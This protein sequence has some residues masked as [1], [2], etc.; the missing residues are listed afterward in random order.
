MLVFDHL[1][2]LSVTWLSWLRPMLEV[3]W[4]RFLDCLSAP[5]LDELRMCLHLR[6]G[7]QWEEPAFTAFQLRSPNVTNLDIEGN[8]FSVPSNALISALRHAP[9]LTHLSLRDCSVDDACLRA[10]SYT[11]GAELLVPHLH[12]LTLADNHVIFSQNALA[13]TIASRWWADVELASP[14]RVPAVARWRQ[15]RL[16]VD[17]NGEGFNPNSEFR[18]KMEDLHKS[19]L[20]IH[21]VEYDSRD[22]AW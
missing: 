5:A 1:R 21:F 18:D 13:S 4:M 6:G 17:S 9:S 19:G 2:I 8:G 15:I 3:H 20:V 16:R 7:A 22:S 14:S 12:S 11:D 10:L